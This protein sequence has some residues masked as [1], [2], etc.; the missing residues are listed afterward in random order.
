MKIREAQTARTGST[1][2]TANLTATRTTQILQRAMMIP[3][4]VMN[5][6]DKVGHNALPTKDKMVSIDLTTT[7]AQTIIT[8]LTN[9][10]AT[11]TH[12]LLY[13]IPLLIMVI[14]GKISLEPIMTLARIS[15]LVLIL[16]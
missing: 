1:K 8:I 14:M 2:R 15:T 7:N 3:I 11:L 4:I 16:T 12:I 5:M 13:S 9:I 10:V 6:N